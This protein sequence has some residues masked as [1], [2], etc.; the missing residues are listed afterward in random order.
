M[1]LA[2]YLELVAQRIREAEE[3][4]NKEEVLRLCGVTIRALNE[5][6]EKLR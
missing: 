6:I 4:G 2:K 1:Q 5:V 3:K